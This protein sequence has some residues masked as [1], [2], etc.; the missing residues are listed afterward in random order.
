MT[1]VRL[2]ADNG[3]ENF[4]ELM[5]PSEL[6]KLSSKV[7]VSNGDR[8]DVFC[9]IFTAAIQIIS[10]DKQEQSGLGSS[11]QVSPYS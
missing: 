4:S 5:N 11:F 1:W 9:N 10:R 2:Q 8:F 6:K 7:I 3:R